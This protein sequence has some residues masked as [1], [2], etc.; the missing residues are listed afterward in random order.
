MRVFVTGASG[1]IGSAVVPELIATGHHV[2]GLARSDAAAGAI[3][4][5]GG[6]ALRGDLNDLAS[7]RA[8]AEAADG[9]I[10]LAYSHDFSQMEA[11]ARGDRQAIENFGD[12][13]AGTDRPLVI[14]GGV[15]G[16]GTGRFVTEDDRPSQAPHPRTA[17][18]QATLDLAERGVR[19]AVVRLAPT[20]HGDGDHGFIAALIGIA[21]QRGVSGYIG[22]GHNR[23]PAVHRLDAATLFRLA[24]EQ[25]QPGS[26][27]HGVAE[28]GVPVRGVAEVVGRHLNLPVVS[29]P[30]EQ[31]AEHFGWLG[32]FLAAD[33]TASNTLT[34]ERLGWTPTH[35]GLIEDLEL[36]HYFSPSS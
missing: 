20:V 26:V 10:H 19:S 13:L 9:V 28:D 35:P 18:A 21:R 5:A 31:A 36:G 7:L 17:N 3:E 25:A 27:L 4:R 11:A 14:A 32:M 34:R 6:T 29:V 33:V 22:D 30:A 12:V 2:T 15:L 24:L 23:W 8:G 16:L 1:F